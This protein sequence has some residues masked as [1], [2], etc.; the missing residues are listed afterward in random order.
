MISL[1]EDHVFEPN[2]R[3]YEHMWQLIQ[4]SVTVF[5]ASWTAAK[6]ELPPEEFGASFGSNQ[7]EE[8]VFFPTKDVILGAIN[9]FKPDSIKVGVKKPDW[10]T[11]SPQTGTSD[12]S[13]LF[14]L[15]ASV[16]F[17]NFYE[18]HRL[19]IEQEYNSD[20]AGWPSIVNFARVIRNSCSHSGRLHF[21]SPSSANASW[22]DLTYGPG[23]NGLKIVAGEFSLADFV[24]LMIEIKQQFDTDGLPVP[25]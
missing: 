6:N 13:K 5:S 10:P 16:V 23:Q 25:E 8:F 17:V 7:F 14:G 1:S 4:L 3:L 21:S 2:D 20:P 11:M 19:L 12:W 9:G 22:H 18:A 15:I 24:I